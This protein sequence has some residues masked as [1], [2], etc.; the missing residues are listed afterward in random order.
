MV[1]GHAEFVRPDLRGDQ[2]AV[3]K[4]ASLYQNDVGLMWDDGEYL[5]IESLVI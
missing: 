5:A 4:T 1:M 3:L 2:F